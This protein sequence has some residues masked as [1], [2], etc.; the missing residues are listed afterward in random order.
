MELFLIVILVIVLLF[1]FCPLICISI[2]KCFIKI[3]KKKH[4][5]IVRRAIFQIL[6]D[7]HR[8]MCLALDLHKHEKLFEDFPSFAKSYIKRYY[9]EAFCAGSMFII[10]SNTSWIAPYIP[11][12]KAKLIRLNILCAYLKTI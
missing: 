9:P 11:S 2:V 1:V 5:Y 12:D 3:R 8:Y 10:N 7:K 4:R 6:D